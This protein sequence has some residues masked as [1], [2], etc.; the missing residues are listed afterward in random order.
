M[1]DQTQTIAQLQAE[2]ATLQA[3]ITALEA[4]VADSDQHITTLSLLQAAIDTTPDGITVSDATQ[5]DFPLIYINKGFE[6]LTG[7][8]GAEI[9]GRNCRFLQGDDRKQAAL[10][11]VRH[12]VE[13]GQPCQVILRNYRKDGSL[14][15]NELSLFPLYDQKTQTLTHYVGVQHDITKR[16]QFNQER[17]EEERQLAIEAAEHAQ[18]MQFLQRMSRKMNL[19]LS[20]EEVFQAAARYTPQIIPS[21]RTSIALVHKD[22]KTFTIVA[23]EGSEEH[24]PNGGTY[25]L[26]GSDIEKALQS[27]QIVINLDTDDQSLGGL[28]TKINVPLLTGGKVIGTLNVGSYRAHAFTRHHQEMLLQIAPLLASNIESR[29]LFEQVQATLASTEDQAFRLALVNEMGHKLS[30]AADEAHI[31]QIVT[32]YAP[33]IVPAERVSIALIDESQTQFEVYALNAETQELLTQGQTMALANTAVGRAIHQQQ[34]INTPDLAASEHDDSRLLAA[35]FGATLVAPIIVHEQAIGTLNVGHTQTDAY[36]YEDE[37]LLQQVASFL[38]TNIHNKRLLKTAERARQAAET[39]SKAKSTFL[40]NMSHE[41]RTPLHAI[42]GFTR[43]VKRREGSKMAEK[44]QENLDKVLTSANDLL[45]LIDTIL[46]IA[47]IEAGRIDIEP[48]TFDAAALVNTVIASVQPLLK[49]EV[50]LTSTFTEPLP[51]IYSDQHKV[52]Q[53]LLNLLSNAAKFTHEGTIHVQMAVRQQQLIIAVKDTGIGIRADDLNRIF[54]E[55]QQADNSSTRQYGGTGLGLAISRRFAQLLG[56]DLN[57]SSQEGSGSTFTLTLPIHYG[58]HRTPPTTT[59]DVLLTADGDKATVLAIDDNPDVI[60][61]LREALIDSN[62]QVVGTHNGDEGI[63]LA[64]TLQPAAITLD[65]MMPHKNGW[66]V[67]Q[68]LKADPE[69]R[70]I[71]VILVSIVDKKA[72]GYQLGAADYLIKPFDEQ[73]ILLTL[74]RLTQAHD[75]SPLHRLLVVDDDPQVLDMVSQLLEDSEYYV[76][77]AAHGLAALEAVEQQRP[78]LIL[79]DLMMPYLDGFGVIDKL[80]QNPDYQNIPIIVLTSK[81]LSPEETQTLQQNMIQ[82]MQKH[83]LERGRLIEELTKSQESFMNSQSN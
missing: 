11:E 28:R 4:A 64:R 12:A 66:Q 46:D 68:E 40:A 19:A 35:K 83:G 42:I 58:A 51:P 73:D 41:L 13:N 22:Q 52:K 80:R 7:Y 77:T 37:H 21:D 34:V 48:F 47:K 38:G 15:W 2:I 16:L 55:F 29:R 3:K 57:A 32:D 33:R 53:I 36:R 70:H 62:F 17:L 74:K 24:F 14:F 49:T 20:E 25:Q 81:S 39:A 61:L 59:A 56:G 18:H 72:L 10:N 79:L 50:A 6:T 54:D 43:I 27:G 63:A 44:Q 8:T 65:V 23:L 78:D 9:L 82:V 30:L 60:Y 1:S 76:Q 31:Y 69:T 5:P 67:L 75:G 71:P 26:E 45:S